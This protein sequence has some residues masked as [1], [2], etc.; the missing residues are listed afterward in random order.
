MEQVIRARYMGT[1]NLFQGCEDR[2][3]SLIFVAYLYALR[4]LGILA[5]QGP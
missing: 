1:F 5:V 3:C 4:M 2:I